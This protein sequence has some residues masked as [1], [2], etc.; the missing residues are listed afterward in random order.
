[1]GVSPATKAIERFSQP[2]RSFVR[3]SHPKVNAATT[4]PAKVI[5][6][7]A[8]GLVIVTV[9]RGDAPR[10]HRRSP[11]HRQRPQQRGTGEK[12]FRGRL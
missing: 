8:R 1:M 9:R 3:W 12:T 10:V 6:V 11:V 2:A 4:A 5:A 7:S